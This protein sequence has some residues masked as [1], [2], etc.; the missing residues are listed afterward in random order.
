M[1]RGLFGGG[2]DDEFPVLL[3]TALLALPTG[4]FCSMVYHRTDPPP[5]PAAVVGCFAA[6]SAP[7]MALDGALIRFGEPGFA[8]VPYRLARER[9]GLLSIDPEEPVTFDR[10]SDGRYA[11]RHLAG[12]PGRLMRL[13]RAVGGGVQGIQKPADMELILVVAQDGRAIRYER[14]PSSACHVEPHGFRAEPAYRLLTRGGTMEPT[15]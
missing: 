11:V 12:Q 2:G 6:R 9:Y 10:N 4:V 5:S 3:V 15:G 13:A 8:P 7:A 1:K 14:A